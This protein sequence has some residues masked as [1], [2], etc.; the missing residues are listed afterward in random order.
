RL[1]A[2]LAGHPL[3]A[4]WLWRIR[5]EAVRRHAASDGLEIDPWHLAAI[6]EGVRFRMDRGPAMIDRGAI[7]AAAR[8]AFGLWRWFAR[9]DD[10]QSDA[11]ASAA[12]ALSAHE[13][14]SPLLGA[15]LGVRAWLDGDGD[16][17]SLRAAL[18]GYWHRRGLLPVACPL[19]TG[20][21][22][23]S[24]EAPQEAEPWTISFLTALAEE[25]ESGTE[26]LRLLERE[27]FAARTAVRDRRRD[28]RAA[29]AVDI[30]A[31]APVISATS[32][33]G[34]LG[35]AIKNAAALLDMFIARDIAIE[36]THRSKR[37][38]YGLKHLAPWR[39]E[40]APPRRPM[41]G[42]GRGRPPRRPVTV[43]NP[44]PP[45]ANS[46]TLTP[47][48]RQEFDFAD[49]DKLMRQ[50]DQAISRAIAVLDQ[51]AAA[52]PTRDATP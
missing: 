7:F 15:A 11:I 52:A 20:A 38:L 10:A 22:A 18:A 6:I 32:L 34:S 44:A 12:A 28:S 51:F 21:A 41:P 5:L 4:A 1:D 40:I 39:E 42:R 23:L 24:S 31:A 8:H 35:V 43:H 14:D 27:W 30:M 33:A 45:P 29:A 46:L 49:L 16:R 13:P 3:A 19:L 47:L 50:T 17:P 26:L 37:R 25:A 36:V 9:P 48:E 2:R